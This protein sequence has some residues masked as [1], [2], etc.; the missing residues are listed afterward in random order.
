MPFT[1]ARYGT[2]A[3]F[4][5]MKRCVKAVG[6]KGKVNPYAVCRTS[7]YGKP[8]IKQREIIIDKYLEGKKLTRS[9][10]AILGHLHTQTFGKR[11]SSKR[12]HLSGIGVA[13]DHN[14]GKS[15]YIK[16]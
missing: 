9:E 14:W 15:L 11:L 13:S 7:I 1:K 4:Q 6:T 16:R 3:K 5:K 2:K 12:Y 8:T 10:S